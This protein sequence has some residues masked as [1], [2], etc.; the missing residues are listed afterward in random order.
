MGGGPA[1]LSPAG[2][3]AEADLWRDL[4]ARAEA[5]EATTPDDV[6][7]KRVL[8]AEATEAIGR[9]EAGDHLRDLNNVAST[10]Q[11]L[12]LCFEAMDRAD[13]DGWARTIIRLETI[14]MAR[15]A[16]HN[17]GTELLIKRLEGKIELDF[18]TARRLFTL[19]CSISLRAANRGDQ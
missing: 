19:I 15:R 10:L 18:E 2:H 7:A 12:K 13:I 9:F 16:V 1:H 17:E 11:S 8:V 3:A 4:R 14:D 5:I 6:L